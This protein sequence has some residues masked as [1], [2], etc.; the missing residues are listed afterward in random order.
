M[1]RIFI[2][3]LLGIALMVLFLESFRLLEVLL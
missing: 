1:I 2:L 3:G